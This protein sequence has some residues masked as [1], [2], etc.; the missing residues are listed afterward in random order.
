MYLGCYTD[1]VSG[2]ALPNGVQVP[3]GTNAMTNEA[4]Q[5]ACLGAGYTYAGCEY[6]GEC[7]EKPQPHSHYS[8]T[9]DAAYRVRQRHC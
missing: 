6:A 5:T 1:D 2:R 4:C 9:S 3:G 7:C 8:F